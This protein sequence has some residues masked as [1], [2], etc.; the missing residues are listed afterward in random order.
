MIRFSTYII[1]IALTATQLFGGHELRTKR[2]AVADCRCSV[3]S[4]S[5]V[6]CCCSPI[7]ERGSRSCGVSNGADV[8]RHGTSDDPAK[9]STICR[10]GCN[11]NLPPVST[12]GDTLSEQ[13]LRLIGPSNSAGQIVLISDGI[14][15]PIVP[16]TFGI[17]CGVAAQSLFCR[18]VI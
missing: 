3:N 10:C 14:I 6:S 1:L 18:W 9:T 12:P 11:Q 15:V 16:Q 4:E 17:F 2:C 5:V 13:V 8:C 7:P